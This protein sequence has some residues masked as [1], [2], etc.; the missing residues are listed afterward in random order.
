MK[1][2][3]KTTL[4]GALLGVLAASLSAPASAA[5]KINWR[6]DYAKALAESKKSK[7]PV[8]LNFGTTWCGACQY[9]LNTTA[10]DP[11]FIKESRNWIMVKLDPE[12]SKSSA[13]AAR[14]YGVDGFPTLVFTNSSGKQL[15]RLDGIAAGNWK[16]WL[17]PKLKSAKKKFR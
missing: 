9:F 3:S 2:L 4:S 1:I 12:K 5:Q 16:A 11:S 8:F 15:E 13:Q 17:E 6:T 14:K 10:K 7:K